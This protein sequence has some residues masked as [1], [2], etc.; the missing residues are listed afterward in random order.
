MIQFSTNFI[1]LLVFSCNTGVS[2]RT[3]RDSIS[4]KKYEIPQFSL[5]LHREQEQYHYLE[6]SINTYLQESFYVTSQYNFFVTFTFH[7]FLAANQLFI[8]RLLKIDTLSNRN[9]NACSSVFILCVFFSTLHSN[10]FFL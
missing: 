6:V 8:K 5:D 10:T 2:N 4:K 9:S 1:H 7:Y 3:L